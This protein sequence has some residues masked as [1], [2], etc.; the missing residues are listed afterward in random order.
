LLPQLTF[1]SPSR[2]LPPAPAPAP[3]P[4]LAFKVTSK[5]KAQGGSAWA[6]LRKGLA[7]CWPY[8]AYYLAYAA[9]LSLFLANAASGRFSQEALLLNIAAALWGLLICMCLWP[10]VETL[11]PREETEEGWRIVWAPGSGESSKEQSARTS[12]ST[13]GSKCDDADK[14]GRQREVEELVVAAGSGIPAVRWQLPVA[15]G[16]GA[17]AGGGQDVQ[18]GKISAAL[19]QLQQQGPSNPLQAASGASRLRPSLRISIEQPA[20]EEP[21]ADAASAFDDIT[22]LH[23]HLLHDSDSH[24]QFS[25]EDL[26]PYHRDAAYRIT[27][28][29]IEEE[30]EEKEE[31]DS[32]SRGRGTSSGGGDAW[33]PIR[34]HAAAMRTAGNSAHSGTAGSKGSKSAYSLLARAGSGTAGGDSPGGSTWRSNVGRVAMPRLAAGLAHLRTSIDIMPEGACCAAGSCQDLPMPSAWCP[35]AELA[36]AAPM[37]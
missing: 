26:A 15:G 25:A 11:L 3:L 2:S 30:E 5:D 20:S 22:A 36:L 1:N 14:Q 17:V 24:G 9:C 18:P 33:S 10:P 34:S 23:Q 35:M 8:T 12:R 27:M 32:S 6:A 16:D 37:L 29:S 28:A 7:W 31:E 4:Q 21:E 19:L 13:D